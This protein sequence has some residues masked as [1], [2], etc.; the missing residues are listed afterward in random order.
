[1]K[2]GLSKYYK[3][4]ADKKFYDWVQHKVSLLQVNF[5]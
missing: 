4:K 1:M 2:D 5:V 3:N